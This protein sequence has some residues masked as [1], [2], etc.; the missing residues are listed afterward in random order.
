MDLAQLGGVDQLWTQITRGLTS[1]P[2]T[3]R[4]ISLTLGHPPG[5][6]NQYKPFANAKRAALAMLAASTWKKARS[7]L[8]VSLRPKPS[9][10]S[11][12]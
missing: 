12:R 8:R 6:N 3:Y 9:V 10:P 7:S 11:V 5:I 1:P 4:S 2:P